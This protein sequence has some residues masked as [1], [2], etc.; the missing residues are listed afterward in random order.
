MNVDAGEASFMLKTPK[1]VYR[2]F[3][4]TWFQERVPTRG[5]VMVSDQSLIDLLEAIV[6]DKDW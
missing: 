4:E 1:W 6:S 2:K 3:D 5:M